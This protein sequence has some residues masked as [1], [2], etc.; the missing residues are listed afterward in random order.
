[1]AAAQQ[2]QRS[3]TTHTHTHT[4][5]IENFQANE[6][7]CAPAR[8]RARSFPRFSVIYP[9][10]SRN[11]PAG[12]STRAPRTGYP[13]SSRDPPF[14]VLPRFLRSKWLSPISSFYA[15][16]L[17]ISACSSPIPL[18]RLFRA[19]LVTPT[20]LY[21]TA[22]VFPICANSPMSVSSF[23][24]PSLVFYPIPVRTVPAPS[25]FYPLARSLSRLPIRSVLLTRLL[26]RPALSIERLTPPC[27][28][29]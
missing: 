25:S 29:R 19:F 5:V 18:P 28:C 15:H 24:L 9:R 11:L 22:A 16:A 20:C 7:L 3:L 10:S 17:S 23:A 12:P 1:M 4:H 26:T 6:T 8:S 27:T 2:R 14:L 21:K 13:N